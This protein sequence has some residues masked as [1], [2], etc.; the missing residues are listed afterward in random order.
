M[1]QFDVYR[2]PNPAGRDVAPYVVDLQSDLLNALP[3]RW[4]APLKVSRSI[5]ARVAGLMPDVEVAGKSYTVFTY[6]SGAVPAH[7]LGKCVAS[8]THHRSEFVA[9]VDLLL[10]GI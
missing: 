7:S 2:N 5:P 9:A 1:A 10:S 4:V 6:E 3:S 8:L